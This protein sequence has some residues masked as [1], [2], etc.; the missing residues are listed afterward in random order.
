VER[1]I[2]RFGFSCDYFLA[3][4]ATSNE[5]G[6]DREARPKLGHV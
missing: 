1:C 2:L 5:S 3:G 4:Q 6:D